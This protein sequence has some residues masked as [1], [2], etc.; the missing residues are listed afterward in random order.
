MWARQ[1]YLS[2]KGMKQVND[3][4]VLAYDLSWPRIQ[5]YDHC[6]AVPRQITS[7]SAEL[8]FDFPATYH[9][10]SGSVPTQ[11]ITDSLQ[12]ARSPPDSPP[13]R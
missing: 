12:S 11:L 5:R 13:I 3:M 2:F 10:L 6:L 9:Y 7:H 4:T 1:G 8:Y